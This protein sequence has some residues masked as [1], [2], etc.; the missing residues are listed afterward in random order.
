M[1][2]NRLLYKRRAGSAAKELVSAEGSAEGALLVWHG[3]FKRESS[4]A[5]KDQCTL[6]CAKQ[7]N[8]M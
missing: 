8:Q 3:D 1:I 7:Q 6:K 5:G 2:T 4:T